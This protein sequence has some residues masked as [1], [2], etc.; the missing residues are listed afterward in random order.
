MQTALHHTGL[1]ATVHRYFLPLLVASYILAAT[2][3]SQGLTLKHCQVSL[4]EQ[5][6]LSFSGILLAGL[7]FTAG[8]GVE[9]RDLTATV[10]RPRAVLTGLFF[11]LAAPLAFILL[12][13][14]VMQLWHNPAEA[15]Q[16]LIGL[17]VVVSMPIAGSSTAWSQSANGNMAL[18][19]GL[20]VGS[21]LLS[22]L[23]TPFAL[24]TVGS[25][26]T[27]E[28]ARVLAD[29]GQHQAVGFLT[30]FVVVPSLAGIALRRL[31]GRD[32]WDRRKPIFKLT[33]SL[34]VLLLC[35]VNASASLPQVAANPDWDFLGVICLVTVLLCVTT[36]LTGWM[37]SHFLNVDQ[38]QRNSL[39]YGLGMNN[40]GTGLVLAASSLAFVPSA[41]LP[42]LLYNLVQ[43][44]VAG[45]VSWLR[46]QTS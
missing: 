29:L 42:V 37:V 5:V 44:L 3:P 15:E 22:P 45:A 41:L 25:L 43:H 33:S 21:T 8:L 6:H 14:Q 16:L 38:A 39:I 2:I 34:T 31:V 12:L 40:N 10:L 23:T 19:L 26:I 28:Y 17:A 36:F 46:R 27:G 11:N 32:W 35:Y 20:V 9:L 1:A 24:S 7:L 4:G 13:F 18:S 30:A